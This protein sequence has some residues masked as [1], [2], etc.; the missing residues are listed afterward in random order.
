MTQRMTNRVFQTERADGISAETYELISVLD[1]AL[2]GAEVY[3]EYVEDARRAGAR[4]LADF[5]DEC[6]EGDV[7]RAVKARELLLARIQANG[8]FCDDEEDAE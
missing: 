4:E 7:E 1:H 2:E 5:F 6:R 8:W 3:A